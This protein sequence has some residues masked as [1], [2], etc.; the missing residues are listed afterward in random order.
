MQQ[1]FVAAL[2]E[3]VGPDNVITDRDVMQRFLLDWT[4]RYRG[5]AVAVV[6]PTSIQAVAAVVAACREAGVAIIPQGGNTGL[7]GGSVP[8]PE[9]AQ[10]VLS[11]R[12]MQRVDPVDSGVR[13][14]VSEAGVPLAALQQHVADAGLQL[15][16]DLA[17]RDTATV[18]GLVATNAGGPLAF[19]YGPVREQVNGVEGVTGEGNV[20]SNIRS[21]RK[22][23]TGYALPTLLIGSEGTLGVVTRVRFK[24]VP[25]PPAELTLL[26]GLEDVTR[27]LE[28]VEVFR[29]SPVEL[30]AAEL[31]MGS[32]MERIL[33]VA[34]RNSPLPGAHPVYLLLDVSGDG[35]LVE[36][37][38]RLVDQ[39]GTEDVVAGTDTTSR[40]ELWRN[41]EE[42]SVG[43]AELAR[44]AGKEVH[45]ADVAVPLAHL[46]DFVS[47]A[48]RR[49]AGRDVLVFGHVGD[50][51]LHVNVLCD[52]AD[53]DH[54]DEL[55]L[56]LAVSL[57]GSIS[58]EHGIGVS[59]R[60]WLAVSRDESEIRLLQAV[61]AAFDPD[62]IMNPGV[63]L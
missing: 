21:V 22:E 19:R 47:T 1:K 33:A 41:R 32:A 16:V 50:G 56:G 12:R 10:I 3:S 48:T 17:A 5:Q 4:G 37:V 43:I 23:N 63:L 25:R 46:D 7:V 18:G 58:A 45:K 14:V 20:I 55:I 51:N 15:G 42:C 9:G 54:I 26:F 29:H 49:L 35:D 13:E 38:A 28:A 30:R 44:Q 61:K 2:V 8:R 11:T 6:T 52:I 53:H 27:A 24:L 36:A 31:I 40:R 59:K 60:E 39:V 62:E 34:G 57:D